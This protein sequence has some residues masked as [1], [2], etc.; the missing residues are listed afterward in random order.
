MAL[1][2]IRDCR[3]IRKTKPKREHQ[4]N[5]HLKILKKNKEDMK[6]KQI[7]IEFAALNF[8]RISLRLIKNYD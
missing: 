7:E 5:E 4:E 2:L 6:N 8:N 1:G 3:S